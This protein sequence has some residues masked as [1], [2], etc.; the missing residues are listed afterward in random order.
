[1]VL[2]VHCCT[3][4]NPGLNTC[5]CSELHPGHILCHMPCE[6][7]HDLA[8]QDYGKLAPRQCAEQATVRPGSPAAEARADSR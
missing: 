7:H 1:M 5:A 3:L 4:L 6:A 2:M 8:A